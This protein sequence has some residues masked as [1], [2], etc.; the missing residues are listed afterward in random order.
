MWYIAVS[1]DRL[2]TLSV[3]VTENVF[4]PVDDMSIALPLVTGP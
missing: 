4:V 1:V 2:P 3:A